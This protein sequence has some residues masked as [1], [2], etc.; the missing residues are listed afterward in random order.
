MKKHPKGVI[1]KKIL[2]ITISFTI[3]AISATSLAAASNE[4]APAN[5]AK[6]AAA[7][8]VEIP[9]PELQ[10]AIRKALDKPVEAI[11]VEDMESLT[12]LDASLTN[13]GAGIFFAVTPISN[14]TGLETA[15]NL[16]SLDL[17]G[18]YLFD[19]V[20]NLRAVDF[21]PLAYLSNLT[22]LDLS[23]NFLTNYSL[24]EGLS[25]LTTLDLS[26]NSLTTL[27]LPEGL[28]SLTTLD[29]SYNWLRLTN[30]TLPEGL[31]NLTTLH[32]DHNRLRSLSLPAS[33]ANLTWLN[34]EKNLLTEFPHI[35]NPSRLTI[36][37]LAQNQ[38]EVVTL[39]EGFD[40]LASLRLVSNPLKQVEVPVSMDLAEIRL[41]GFS[42]AEV[43]YYMYLRFG[44]AAS[45][46]ISQNR[47]LIKGADGDKVFIQRSED[48]ADWND[49]NCVILG[50]GGC[51]L[52]ENTEAAEQY[53]YRAIIN[54]SIESN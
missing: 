39:P 38:L 33:L 27:T 43:D 21:T 37:D 11:T 14:L 28:N 16:I 34:L 10:L 44:P 41:E 48:L 6:T 23:Y 25:N 4:P 52:F 54:D 53:F 30:Y 36:L 47:L 40:S 15:K 9:D 22:T 17:S 49:W 18:A 35:G 8:V 31:S 26:E 32:L 19:Y 51:Q 29:L 24:P 12:E 45:A 42:L 20:G 3:L 7:Q 50:E 13:R 5:V 1:M 2:P 46:I